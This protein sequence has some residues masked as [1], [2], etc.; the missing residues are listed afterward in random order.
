MALPEDNLADRLVKQLDRLQQLTNSLVGSHGFGCEQYLGDLCPDEEARIQA[1]LAYLDPEEALGNLY[2]YSWNP[3][4]LP[5]PFLNVTLKPG[6]YGSATVNDDGFRAAHK[7]GPR[8]ERVARVILTGGSVAFGSGAPDNSTTIAGYMNAMLPDYFEVL[9]F[10]CPAWTTTHERIAIE[11]RLIELEPDVVISITG[12]NDVFWSLIGHNVMAFRTYKDQHWWRQLVSLNKLVGIDIP[13]PV[14]VSD[15][16]VSRPDVIRRFGLNTAIAHNA[17]SN[18]GAHYL[19]AL[20]PS[21]SKLQRPQ[22]ER[23]QELHK[24]K[25]TEGTEAYLTL[26]FSGFEKELAT[27]GVTYTDLSD[28]LDAPGEVFID[29]CHMGDRGN[30][31]VAEHL[32]INVVDLL[33]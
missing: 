25:W 11:N 4:Q 30:L 32:A 13:D 31:L 16:S 28:A 12:F 8:P 21:I 26:C 29:Q 9:T 33:S 14:S 6:H 24:R 3:P 1:S 22:T 2:H 23:E 5:T 17:L 7:V 18:V 27:H 20:Q 19:V 10:A 15:K